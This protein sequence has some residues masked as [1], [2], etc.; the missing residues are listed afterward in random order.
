MLIRK[1]NFSSSANK[2]FNFFP[3]LKEETISFF[4]WWWWVLMTL[5]EIYTGRYCR[6]GCLVNQNTVP[7][8]LRVRQS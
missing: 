1:M 2:H 7:M 6:M 3:F 4:L 8:C 5:T